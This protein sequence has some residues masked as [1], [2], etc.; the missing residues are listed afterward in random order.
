MI[1]DEECIRGFQETRRKSKLKPRIAVKAA[2]QDPVL[3]NLYII[4]S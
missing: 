2:A 1:G 4:A 3:K